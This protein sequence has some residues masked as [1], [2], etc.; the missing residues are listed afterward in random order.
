MTLVTVERTTDQCAGAV[1]MVRPAAFGFNAETASTNHL[2]RPPDRL[3]AHRDAIAALA[4]FDAM[5]EKLRFAGIRVGVLQD[6]PEPLRP[7]AVFPNNWVSFHADGTCVLYPMQ[8]ASRRRERRPEAMQ[9]VVRELGFDLRRTVDLTAAENEG[10]FL[11]GTGSLVLDHVHR[12]AYCARSPR[13]H[14]SVARDWCMQMGFELEAFDAAT[15]DG[16]SIY[17]TNILLWIGARVAAVGLDWI[18]ARDRARVAA[19]LLATGRDVIELHA[20]QLDAFAGNM[21]E[22]R[23]ARGGTCLVMSRTAADSLALEQRR[24][25]EAATDR[26]LPID[27][28]LI[29]LRGGG[30]VRCMLAEV[31]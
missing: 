20:A 22:V 4:Q 24:R 7:D 3:D 11:E 10:R 12:V 30:S 13:S 27:V 23:D 8:S 21:L 18:D 19:R 17:H 14:E 1:C 15:P 29:E 9:A 6:E 26:V 25:I 16:A 31:P 2:Q 5:V 28:P